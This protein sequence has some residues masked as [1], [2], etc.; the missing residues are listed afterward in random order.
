[1][2]LYGHEDEQP[3]GTSLHAMAGRILTPPLRHRNVAFEQHSVLLNEHENS[4]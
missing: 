3:I 1:M 4:C 2:L